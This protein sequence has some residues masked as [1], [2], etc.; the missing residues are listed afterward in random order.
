MTRSV[1]ILWRLFFAGFGL[2]LV[3]M[4]CANFGLFGKMPSIKELENPE[5]DLASEIISSDGLLMGKYYSENRS[6]VKYSEISPNII[7]ALIATEDERFYDHSGIDAQAL[8]RVAFTAGTQGGGSTIT[9][10]VAKMMLGQGRGNILKRGIDK[11]KEWI[12][13]VKLERNFTKEEIITLYLNRAPWG[14]V[15][16]I[17]NAS[18][19]YFQKEP[20]DLKIEEA[21]VLIGMLKGFIY[22]PIRSPKR[23]IDRRNTVINQMAVAHQKFL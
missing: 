16:G 10:Q 20:K 3:M 7:N 2:F 5:A 6:E 12:V 8:A 4:L 18:R 15:Y 21:A 19:T 14:N 23:S 9:Q 13:A 17:R 11:L 1:R 22:D